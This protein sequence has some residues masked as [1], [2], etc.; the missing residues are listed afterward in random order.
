MS[1]RSLKKYLSELSKAQLEDQ[2]LDLYDR[3]KEVKVYYNFAFNPQESKLIEECKYKI[4]NEY[5]PVTR[6][7]AKARRSVAQKFIKHF[8][9][10]GVDPSLIADVMLFNIETTQAY[11]A[12]KENLP[13][14]FTKSI[15]S[16]FKQCIQYL[17]KHELTINH[18]ERINNIV[19]NTEK[20]DWINSFAFKK[21]I[22]A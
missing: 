5:F 15:L 3:F 17:E 19:D 6:K 20:Q 10:I 1:K 2:L 7:K 22:S 11:S 18:K 12:E 21:I 9:Q 16:S 13:D 14:T 4:A 8:I